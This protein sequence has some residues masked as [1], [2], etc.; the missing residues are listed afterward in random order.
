MKTWD[1][2]PA[3]GDYKMS[4]GSPV[5]TN[6]LT[7]PCYIRLKAKRRSWLYAPNENW[8]SDLHLIKKRGPSVTTLLENTAARAVKPIVDDGRASELEVTTLQTARNGVGLNCK[9]T[10]A[11]GEVEQLQINPVGR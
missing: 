7:V 3:T 6:E 4:G 5:E 10:D 9:I 8:G 2:D 11:Q 1:L